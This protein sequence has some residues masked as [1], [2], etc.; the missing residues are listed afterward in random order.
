MK[1]SIS[2]LGVG[3]DKEKFD[4]IVARVVRNSEEVD[5]IVNDLVKKYCGEL[6]DYMKLIDNLINQKD[7]VADTQL[8]DFVLNLP[9]LL[10]FASAAQEALGIKEDVAK[11]IRN[12]VYNR[13]REKAE[14]TIA[15]KDILRTDTFNTIKK[16]F[17][18]IKVCCYT[19][20][21]IWISFISP[22]CAGPVWF[23]CY[24]CG[25]R[26]TSSIRTF[27]KHF[28]GEFVGCIINSLFVKFIFHG[29]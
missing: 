1:E 18:K 21:C 25:F 15:D 19:Q 14:G 2:G 3:I 20:I 26:I 4:E 27:N 16:P 6:D 29:S 7:P 22:S 23:T 13:V 5:S 12:E 28:F 11:A 17:N 9:A 10:Y 8:D 24:F